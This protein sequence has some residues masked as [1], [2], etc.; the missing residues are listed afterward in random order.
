MSECNVLGAR[1]RAFHASKPISKR[2][3]PSSDLFAR[4]GSTSGWRRTKRVSIA[5]CQNATFWAQERELFMRRNRFQK[6]SVRPPI[7][8]QGLA[9]PVDGGAQNELV[10]HHVRMQRFGRKK[11]SFSCVETDFKKEASVLANTAAT[12]YG[13]PNGGKA[14]KKSRSTPSSG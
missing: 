8:S 5:S 13:W 3:R 1:K 9:R 7:C 2:K 14:G 10:L 4:I 11:E 12:K 6:G